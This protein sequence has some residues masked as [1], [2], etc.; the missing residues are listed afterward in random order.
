M[1]TI[2]TN[3]RPLPAPFSTTTLPLPNT[4][5]HGAA[6]GTFFKYLRWSFAIN[7][8]LG[9]FYVGLVIVPYAVQQ[10]FDTSK[11]MLRP[12]PDLDFSAGDEI[13]G[14]FTGGVS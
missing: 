14:L 5:K 2:F 8:L 12:K 3:S 1:D 9:L 10:G 11:R 13:L 6:V 7:L 4:G